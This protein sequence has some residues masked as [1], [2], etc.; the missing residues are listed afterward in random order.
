MRL[1]GDQVV[2]LLL[3]DNSVAVSVGPLDHL[4]KD[5]IVSQLSQV[6]SHLPEVLQRNEAGLLRIEG[7][8]H[9]MHL[10]SGFV[11]RG[12]SGHHVEE[13][14]EL[15]LPAPVLVQLSDH[16]VH[17]LRLSL[18]SQ[19]VDR[20]L[21]FC[22]GGEL[23]LGSMAPPRSRSKKSKAFLI[24]VTSSTVIKAEA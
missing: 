23:P 4:L 13:L 11:V 21:Q 6:L 24:S 10:V 22:I 15:D 8:E 1:L 9:L 5:A 12:T 19:R 3:G 17:C 7:N 18:N 2:E 20:C 14:V 16:L